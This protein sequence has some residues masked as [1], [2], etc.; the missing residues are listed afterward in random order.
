MEI[1]NSH[2]ALLKKGQRVALTATIIIPVK[3]MNGL[4]SK[5]HGH[6]GRAPYFIILKLDDKGGAEI[7]DFYHNRFWNAGVCKSL[8]EE[9]L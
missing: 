6:F 3:E 9:R 5:I 7:E 4:D 8:S 2:I 1:T